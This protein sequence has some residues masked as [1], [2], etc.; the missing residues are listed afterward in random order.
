MVHA[1]EIEAAKA[2]GAEAAGYLRGR[3]WD[4]GQPVDAVQ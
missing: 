4:H 1:S 2:A 3:T